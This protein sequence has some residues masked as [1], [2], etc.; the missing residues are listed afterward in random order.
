VAAL[1]AARPD[2]ALSDAVLGVAPG[3]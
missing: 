2:G 1:A 3:N